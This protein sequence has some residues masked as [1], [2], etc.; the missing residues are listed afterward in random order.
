MHSS[1]KEAIK[2]LTE[3]LTH[4]S[5]LFPSVEGHAK[6]FTVHWGSVLG[7]LCAVAQDWQ[8]KTIPGLVT[9]VGKNF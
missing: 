1:V 8:I 3:G 6:W 9:S 4:P 7:L 5:A 2:L